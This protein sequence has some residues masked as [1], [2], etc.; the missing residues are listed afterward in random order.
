MILRSSVRL[1][2]VNILFPFSLAKSQRGQKALD[3]GGERLACLRR[4]RFGV[5]KEAT[6]TVVILNEVDLALAP[7][8]HA[9]RQQVLPTPRPCCRLVGSHT[10]QACQTL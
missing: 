10:A 5:T 4:M 2:W 3:W 1:L 8:H 7:A 9:V 6:L